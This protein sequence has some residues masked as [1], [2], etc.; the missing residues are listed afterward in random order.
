MGRPRRQ[1]PRYPEPEVEPDVP[2]ADAP[3]IQPNIAAVLLNQRVI[4]ELAREV[5]GF[6]RKGLLADLF[7]Q[8][9]DGNKT[10]QAAFAQSICHEFKASKPGSI[11]RQRILDMMCRLINWHSDDVKILPVEEMTEEEL[12]SAINA[13]L[14][15]LEQFAATPE[16]C[17]LAI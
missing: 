1:V 7:N 14:P 13:S 12:A 11:A 2:E 9:V 16:P 6:N 4:R 5:P 10:G 3:L 8:W 17:E 15:R